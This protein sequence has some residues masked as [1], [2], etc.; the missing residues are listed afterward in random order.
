MWCWSGNAGFGEFYLQ[1]AQSHPLTGAADPANTTAWV[2]L[3][4]GAVT[5]ALNGY[6]Y[7]LFKI[8]LQAVA[9]DYP[10]IDSVKFDWEYD[11]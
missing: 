8:V 6:R 7:F 9:G 2:K 4:S 5:T 10:E 11:I 3:G 1:G